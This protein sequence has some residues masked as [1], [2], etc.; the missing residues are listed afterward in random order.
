MAAA[1]L[2]SSPVYGG[3]PDSD[4]AGPMP[5]QRPTLVFV[6]VHI[7]SDYSSVNSHITFFISQLT[8]HID[9]F[10]HL[11][12]TQHEFFIELKIK[13]YIILK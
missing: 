10:Q 12:I 2:P 3:Q 8:I 7:T 6:C 1:L 5:V 11:K 4:G 13:Y 9:L